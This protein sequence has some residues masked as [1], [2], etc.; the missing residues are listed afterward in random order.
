MQNILIIFL[1]FS[2]CNGDNV[3]G[4]QDFG[5]ELFFSD[6]GNVADFYGQLQCYNVA[7]FL[8]IAQL[9]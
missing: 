8:F 2:G 1:T 9:A 4:L 7:E 3:A 6:C 5:S